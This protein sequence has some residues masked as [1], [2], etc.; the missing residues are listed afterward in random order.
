MKEHMESAG[1]GGWLRVLVQLTFWEMEAD[2]LAGSPAACSNPSAPLGSHSLH[3]AEG[4]RH[5]FCA[6]S[7]ISSLAKPVGS[8]DEYLLVIHK[9][10]LYFQPGS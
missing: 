6:Q 9:R 1:M 10:I 4:G 7:L 2:G 8:C 3:R 5:F